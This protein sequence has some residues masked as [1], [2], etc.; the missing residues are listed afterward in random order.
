MET[1][2]WSEGNFAFVEG[3]DW[4]WDKTRPSQTTGLDTKT[5]W[6]T[7]VLRQPQLKQ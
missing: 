2:E 4:K 1:V 5:R 7:F 6:Q 3:W